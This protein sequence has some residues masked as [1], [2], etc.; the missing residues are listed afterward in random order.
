MNQLLPAMHVSVSAAGSTGFHSID[1]LL[2]IRGEPD[3]CSH[4]FPTEEEHRDRLQHHIHHR[5]DTSG[6]AFKLTA[7]RVGGSL[8]CPFLCVLFC[9][10]DR[11][12]Y[13][14]FYI[15]R[16]MRR[17]LFKS[18]LKVEFDGPIN[19]NV[20]HVNTNNVWECYL[21]PDM[22]LVYN[23]IIELSQNYSHD[24][25]SKSRKENMKNI[26]GQKQLE[27][28]EEQRKKSRRN[29][30]TFTTYQLHELERAFEKSHYPDVYSR[31]ELAMKIN[32]PE[33]RVQVWFQNRR[34]KWRRQEKLES[35]AIKI[36]DTYPMSALTAKSGCGFGTSLPLDPWMT[37]P[38]TNNTAPAHSVSPMTS[39]SSSLST[40]PTFISS[41]VFNS[42]CAMSST[43][44]ALSGVFNCT[45]GKIPEVDTR[46]SSIVSLRMKAK[47]HMDLFERKY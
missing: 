47:E 31:E 21:S 34:A 12:G 17:S 13:R 11:G 30:T 2:G 28:S 4:D 41:P 29:R 9:L 23:S 36:N 6:R 40:Y 3:M 19:N 42:N 7:L 1:A 33:V 27:Y 37:S 46:N 15:Q 8:K 18:G 10:R 26:D 22:S 44:H 38:I 35:S 25:N 16:L 5:K 14:S 32:L 43:L 45:S 20:G 24:K 39:S